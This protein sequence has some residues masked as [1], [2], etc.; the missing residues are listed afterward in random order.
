MQDARTL[1]LYLDRGLSID[2]NT[3]AGEQS[4]RI[5]VD[6]ECEMNLKKFKQSST[7]RIM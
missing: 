4:K 1:P 3:F 7:T 5:V 2:M 6:N